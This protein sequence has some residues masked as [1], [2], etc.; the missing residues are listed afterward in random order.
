MIFYEEHWPIHLIVNNI[1]RLCFDFKHVFAR[2]S[3]SKGMPDKWCAPSTRKVKLNV[4]GSYFDRL[5]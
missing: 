2:Y 1:Y 5:N 4:D 3:A